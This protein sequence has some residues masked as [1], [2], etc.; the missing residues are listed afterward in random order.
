MTSSLNNQFF[1]TQLL[2]RRW[3]SEKAFE[4]ALERPPD[5]SFQPGQRIQLFHEDIERDYS[6]ISAPDDSLLALCIRNVKGGAMSSVLST[7]DVPV[8]IEFTGP[9]GYFI[10]QSSPR[11][12]IMVATGTGI[13]PFCSMVRS[14]IT[15]FTLLHGVEKSEELYYAPEIKKSAKLYVPCLSAAVK[16]KSTHFHGRVTDYLQ[17]KLPVTVYD[18][19]LCGRREMIR[20]VTL[21]VDERFPGSHIY[22]ELFY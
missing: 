20:D 9:H 15:G 5:F 18:F 2:Q 16:E 6:L 22:T 10:F 4:I 19:Y 13:A 3:L 8:Q 11:P 17:D 12:P 21:L 7:V 1:T 14:G